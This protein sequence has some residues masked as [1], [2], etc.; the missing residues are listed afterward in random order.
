[1]DTIICPEINIERWL[2]SEVSY[3]NYYKNLNLNTR[4]SGYY[5]MIINIQNQI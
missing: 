3:L 2:V 4:V 1:M 5:K